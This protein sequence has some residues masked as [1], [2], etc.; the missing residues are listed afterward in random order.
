MKKTLLTA[1]IIAVIVL[2]AT[3]F[4]LFFAEFES[5]E[6]NNQV[7]LRARELLGIKLENGENPFELGPRID[8][9]RGGSF[10]SLSGRPLQT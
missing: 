3:T 1:G 10:F 9:G 5:P 4:V 6:L 2:M 8:M 7:R